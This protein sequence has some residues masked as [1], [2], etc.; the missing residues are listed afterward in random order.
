MSE[1]AL[2]TRCGMESILARVV[3]VSCA[4]QPHHAYPYANKRATRMKVLAHDGQ[5]TR[6]RSSP[7]QG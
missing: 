5:R 6:V 7:F 3:Q 4:A 1:Q 2:D